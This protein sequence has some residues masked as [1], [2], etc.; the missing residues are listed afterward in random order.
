MAA[1]PMAIDPS[2]AERAKDRELFRARMAKV[3]A[4]RDRA[5]LQ[6]ADLLARLDVPTPT[7]TR[8]G[9][10]MPMPPPPAA[11]A[12]APAPR[13]PPAS[14]ATNA[15][16]PRLNAEALAMLMRQLPEDHARRATAGS[17]AFTASSIASTVSDTAGGRDML[18]SGK[19]TMGLTDARKEAL[20]ALRMAVE[21]DMAIMV[22]EKGTDLAAQAI[23]R[24]AI[25]S[26]SIVYHPNLRPSTVK[27]KLTK[28]ANG[29]DQYSHI[30][31]LTKELL[32]DPSGLSFD[33]LEASIH[34]LG[35]ADDCVALPR[36]MRA[37]NAHRATFQTK[38]PFNRVAYM[39]V[40]G[41]V[42]Q[43]FTHETRVDVVHVIIRTCSAETWANLARMI[44]DTKVV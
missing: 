26:L 37:L 28:S 31:P 1:E 38:R 3:I 18:K 36:T 6:S 8:E 14:A 33:R 35:G 22:R 7:R 41:A 15:Q 9:T 19:T 29:G 25:L 4:A 20:E 21:D 16:M 32:H 39:E 17:V 24:G 13:A 2:A 30:P 42:M 43:H 34:S 12:P 5:T 10:P 23:G 40:Y 27:S 11:P 44:S